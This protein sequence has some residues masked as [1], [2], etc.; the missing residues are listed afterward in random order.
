MRIHEIED[1]KNR[2]EEL[3][4]HYF[5]YSNF[6]ITDKGLVID[7]PCI[8]IVAPSNGELPVK[9]LRI[10]G[11]FSVSGAK[12]KTLKGCPEIIDGTFSLS[13][14]NLT[15]LEGGP[16]EVYGEYLCVNNPIES[17][18]GLPTQ[19]TERI[20]LDFNDEL[21]M[22]N[23]LFVKDLKLFEFNGGPEQ[24]I[25]VEQILN[26]YLRQGRKG[27][28]LCAAELTRAGFKGNARL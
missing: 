12:L 27:A 6:E 23:L 1:N 24:S 7:G 13:Y 14:N 25:Q 10:N 20:V 26:K 2:I 28:I 11:D 16:K 19:V 22:L 9:F 21:P 4:N 18:N 5:E 8:L 15:S 3:L 17:L